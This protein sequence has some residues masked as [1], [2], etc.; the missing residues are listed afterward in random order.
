MPK[1]LKNIGHLAICQK[2][3]LTLMFYPIISLKIEA[4]LSFQLM[5]L[6]L[7]QRMELINH[8]GRINLDGKGENL[9]L[10]RIGVPFLMITII[11]LD[12]FATQNVM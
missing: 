8:D 9:F 6:T 7:T 5:D 10:I 2:D 4:L 12:S 11:Y 3:A 1:I